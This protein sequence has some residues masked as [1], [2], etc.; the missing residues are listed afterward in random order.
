MI[1]DCKSPAEALARES[2]WARVIPPWA[3]MPANPL[4]ASKALCPE[5]QRPLASQPKAAPWVRMKGRARPKGAEHRDGLV[6]VP[7]FQGWP[8]GLSDPQGGVRVERGL[9]VGWLGSGRWPAGG[10]AAD[11]FPESAGSCRL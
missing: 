3:P 8:F 1:A 6:M 4:A 7:P 5:C 9:A 10:V 11:R 2:A